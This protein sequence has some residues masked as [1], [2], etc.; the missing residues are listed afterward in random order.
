MK[1]L[2]I[3]NILLLSILLVSGT[4]ILSVSYLGIF[5][6]KFI[7]SGFNYIYLVIIDLISLL[8]LAYYNIK[9]K[10]NKFIGYLIIL[11]ISLILS[12]ISIS[13]FKNYPLYFLRYLYSLFTLISFIYLIKN[14]VNLINSIQKN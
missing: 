8:I 2:S 9:D 11:I 3:I 7:E 13:V 1:K 5:K 10:L 14:I 4:I 12:L 6:D